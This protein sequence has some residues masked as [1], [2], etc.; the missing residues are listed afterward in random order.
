MSVNNDA[1]KNR[2][3]NL[4]PYQLASKLIKYYEQV[5]LEMSAAMQYSEKSYIKVSPKVDLII[6]HSAIILTK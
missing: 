2:K 1:N 3:I 5:A 6:R 4:R